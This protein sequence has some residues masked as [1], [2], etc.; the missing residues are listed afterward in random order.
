MQSTYPFLRQ[1][2]YLDIPYEWEVSP[3]GAAWSIISGQ[4]GITAAVTQTDSISIQSKN[5]CL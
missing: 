2:L 3:D 1:T 5:Y 4:S